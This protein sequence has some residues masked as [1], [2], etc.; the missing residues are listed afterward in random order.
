MSRKPVVVPWRRC[1]AE[2]VERIID[3]ETWARREHFD[4]FR[5]WALPHFH[6]AAEV[7]IT[8]L[9]AALAEGSISFTSAIVYVLARA[10]NDLP[11]FRQRIRGDTVVE[12]D[13]V[14]PSS[15]ILVDD[16]LFSFCYFEY[17]D[18]LGVFAGRFDERT[19]AA[20]A[21]PTLAEL[22]HRDDL[23]FMTAI[24]W[25]SFTCFMHPMTTI[26]PDSIPRLAWGKFHAAAARILMP[27]GVQGHHALMDGLHVGRYFDEVQHYLDAPESYLP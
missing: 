14:H 16:D 11:E 27:L 2:A 19:A 4:T 25:I 8:R 22:D 9:R 7:D 24:P 20:K 6:V 18:D 23:L 5:H 13:V 12:H 1:D 26:P 15:T 21:N 10:A 3:P 17:T